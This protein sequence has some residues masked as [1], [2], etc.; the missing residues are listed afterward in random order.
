MY[1]SG[2]LH[3]MVRPL[4]QIAV[5]STKYLI[6]LHN[7]FTQLIYLERSG[8]TVIRPKDFGEL[9]ALKTRRIQKAAPVHA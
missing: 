9:T 6:I 2:I 8:G 1:F 3:N 4:L 7:Y 5:T